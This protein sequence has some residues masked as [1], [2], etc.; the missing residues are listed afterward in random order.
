MDGRALY[1]I[2][3]KITPENSLLTLLEMPHQALALLHL[4]GR[5]GISP[6]LKGV[7]TIPELD[8]QGSTRKLQGL[9]VD[10]L[11]IPGVMIGHFIHLIAMDNDNGGILATR[12]GISHFDTATIEHRRRVR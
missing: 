1:H 11:E 2:R 4:A 8:S 6:S 5:Q 10:V 9:A 12:M 3:G 7:L